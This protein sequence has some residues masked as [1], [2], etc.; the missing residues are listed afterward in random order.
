[1]SW[2]LVL[3][4]AHLVCT[5]G[6][7]ERYALLRPIY[8]ENAKREDVHTEQGRKRQIWRIWEY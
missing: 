6:D 1:M 8:G 4:V 5:L 3:E 2:G 7:I